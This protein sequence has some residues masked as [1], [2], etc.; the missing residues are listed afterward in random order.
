MPCSNASV[1]RI[2][3]YK[4]MLPSKNLFSITPRVGTNLQ[5][6][7]KYWVPNEKVQNIMH[8]YEEKTNLHFFRAVANLS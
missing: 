6:K 4:K 3:V 7:K 1:D 2:P 5:K 8:V